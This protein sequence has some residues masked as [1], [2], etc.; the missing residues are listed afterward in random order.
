MY[1][2]P[3]IGFWKP[4]PDVQQY[5]KLAVAVGE[6]LRQIAPE[7]AYIG[8]ATSQI[9]LPFLEACFKAGLLQHWSAVSVHPYRQEAP[10][11]VAGEY[12]QLRRLIVQYAPQGKKVPILSGEWGYSAAWRNYDEAKQGRL[13]PRQWLINLLNDV[14]L[15]I[16]YD[17]HDDGTDPKNAE[18]HFGTVLNPYLAG[19]EPTTVSSRK[20]AT[21]FPR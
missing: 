12:A 3:N 15:S 6:A 2:E 14:P 4:K 18:H 20:W 7:E 17:W 8:P 5:I 10:E 21:H 1:N 19:R 9:D 16:W 13:L 11:T